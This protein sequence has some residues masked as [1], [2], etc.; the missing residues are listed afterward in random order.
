MKTIRYHGERPRDERGQSTGCRVYAETD[1]GA[2][3]R[4]RLRH[5][6]G[7]RSHS[8]T[9]FEWGYGGSG[10]AELARAIVKDACGIDEPIPSIYQKVKW[11][12]ITPIVGDTFTL[13]ADEVRAFVARE[14]PDA[15]RLGIVEGV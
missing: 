8:P 9:G 5:R 7:P 15:I 3:R 14:M 1:E 10:P 4:V 6:T 11:K 2:G 12:Y 13:D